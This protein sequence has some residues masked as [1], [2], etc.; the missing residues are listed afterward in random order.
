MAVIEL[1]KWRIPLS[2]LP[3]ATKPFENAQ[4]LWVIFEARCKSTENSHANRDFTNL[5]LTRTAVLPISILIAA[6]HFGHISRRTD[7]AVYNLF[8]LNICNKCGV[9]RARNSE[10]VLHNF[11]FKLNPQPRIAQR[12]VG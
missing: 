3:I 12:K 6:K 9:L 7:T 5:C 1:R 2:N 11:I 10:S 4:G 8:N